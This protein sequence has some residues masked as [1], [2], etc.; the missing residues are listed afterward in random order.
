MLNLDPAFYATSRIFLDERERIF[1]RTWQLIGPTSRLR[2]AGDY[3]ATEVAGLKLFVLRGRDGGLRLP[4]CVP[5]SR[6]AAA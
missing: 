6:R 4:Q 1:S 2:E 5:P 3:V